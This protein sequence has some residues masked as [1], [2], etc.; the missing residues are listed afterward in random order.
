MRCEDVT[1]VL[2]GNDQT[3]ML[4]RRAAL[5]HTEHC[6]D[7]LAAAHA[8]NALIDE[9]LTPVPKLPERSFARAVERAQSAPPT[10]ANRRGFWLGTAVGGVLAASLALG[11]VLLAPQRTTEPPARNPAVVLAQDELHEV[12]VSLNSPEALQSA[13]IRVVLTGGVELQGFAGQREL[14]WRTDLDR[15]VNQ[16][17][18]PLIGRDASRGQVTVEVQHGA[19]VRTF[20][21]DVEPA[22]AGATPLDETA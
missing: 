10:S 8:V 5:A 12:S 13:E 17:T 9:R 16:L 20:V 19:R 18:L 11:V 6:E 21:I 3:D 2:R 15:G 7:C 22:G 1:E 4:R 14:R